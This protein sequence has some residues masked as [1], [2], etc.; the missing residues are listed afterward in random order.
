MKKNVHEPGELSGKIQQFVQELRKEERSD[1]TIE[2][3]VRDVKQFAEWVGERP[4]TKELILLWKEEL[5]SRYC[6][7]TV[8]GKLASINRFLEIS[9]RMEWR[10]KALKIQRRIF[11]DQRKELTK[12]EYERLVTEA[13]EQGKERLALLMETICATGIRVSELSYVTMEAVRTGKAEISLKG[14]IRVILLPGKLC[15]KLSKYGKKYGINT[16]QL[17][18]TRNGTPVSRKQ[19]W[20]EMKRLCKEAGIE[21]SKVFPHNLRHLFARCFYKACRDVVRLADIL[22]HSSVDTTRVYLISSGL[23]HER[24]LEGLHLIL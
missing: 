4:M 3:Y 6:P 8:N 2:K 15:R 1:G 12:E 7:V 13:R 21:A 22:G 5:K 24:T 10:V 9:G 20:A 11:R 23:E 16:G 18:V 17:F 14:K 19:I